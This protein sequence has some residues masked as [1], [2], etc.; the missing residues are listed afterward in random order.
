MGKVHGIILHPS[1]ADMDEYKEIIKGS[2]FHIEAGFL[3]QYNHHLGVMGVIAYSA[4]IF[5]LENWEKVK[6]W[7][8]LEVVVHDKSSRKNKHT[9][10]YFNKDSGRHG[11]P[12]DPNN[13]SI[14]DRM[15]EKFNDEAHNPVTSVRDIVLDHSDGDFS[16]T[17]NDKEHWWINDEAVIE[18]ADYI[19]EQLKKQATETNGYPQP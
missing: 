10:E 12:P 6:D 18:I 1:S 11:M 5:I 7:S 19:E 13:L 4:K 3:E 17:I 15:F 8:M 16:L 14:I 9:T 2:Q